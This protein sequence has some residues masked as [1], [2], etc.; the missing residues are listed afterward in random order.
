MASQDSCGRLIFRTVDE[1]FMQL[2]SSIE[3]SARQH[4]FEIGCQISIDSVAKKFQGSVDKSQ[5]NA[6]VSKVKLT[7][8]QSGRV[9][10]DTTDLTLAKAVAK[11]IWQRWTAIKAEAV[12]EQAPLVRPLVIGTFKL[13]ARPGLGSI[14]REDGVRRLDSSVAQ[15]DC[16]DDS[17]PLVR[18]RFLIHGD[19]LFTFECNYE[20]L[21]RCHVERLARLDGLVP[22]VE[23]KHLRLHFVGHR[24]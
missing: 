7:F 1:I 5:V 19:G 4:Y 2:N 16:V 14:V 15:Y 3:Y 17:M 6:V 11:D 10:I 18:T 9:L 24:K 21:P 12:S 8:L 20:V 22:L 13:G 23:Q